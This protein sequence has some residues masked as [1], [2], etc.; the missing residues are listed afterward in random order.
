MNCKKCGNEIDKKATICPNCGVKIKKP[1]YK[2]WWF[3]VLIVLVCLVLGA[4][5]GGTDDNNSA[6]NNIITSENTTQ[7]ISNVETKTYEKIELQTMIDDLKENALKAEKTYNNQYI[8]ITGKITN[9]D[10]NGSYISIESETAGDFN[11]DTVSCNIN[12]QEQQNLLLEKSIGDIV[13]I[14][15][16]VTSVG[17]VLGYSI[18]IEE[19]L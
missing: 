10:S 19:I 15:G 9:F 14:R 3:W 18:K 13:T 8:E 17:E 6:D 4:A 5:F 2:K 11:F 12:N 1:I 7:N 16:K